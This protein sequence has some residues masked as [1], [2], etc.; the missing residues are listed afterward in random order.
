MTRCLQHMFS[1][2]CSLHYAMPSRLVASPPQLSSSWPTS[3][4]P[5][6]PYKMPSPSRQQL[7]NISCSWLSVSPPCVEQYPIPRVEILSQDICSSATMSESQMSI[8]WKPQ[9]IT[10]GPYEE[11]LATVTRRK[12]KWYGHRD[13]IRW[14][15]LLLLLRSY[16]IIIVS[17]HIVNSVCWSHAL[18]KGPTSKRPASDGGRFSGQLLKM[19]QMSVMA[20]HT[21]MLHCPPASTSSWMLCTDRSQFAV[22][23]VFS[24]KIFSLD[25]FSWVRYVAMYSGVSGCFP[26]L[27]PRCRNPCILRPVLRDNTL[28]LLSF[29]VVRFTELEYAWRHFIICRVV[30]DVPVV[31]HCFPCQGEGGC[32]PP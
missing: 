10:L 30:Q 32:F 5:W 13:K 8:M 3:S 18:V 6:D 27:L 7:D 24:T 25:A 16:N 23:P 20:R 15:S 26:L 9:K 2:W 29:L 4:P 17:S 28:H 11:D 31:F 22:C 12:R 21:H 1:P 14:P 19:C